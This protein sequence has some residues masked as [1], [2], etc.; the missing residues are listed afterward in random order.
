MRMAFG[1]VTGAAAMAALVAGL[2]AAPSAAAATV[3]GGR[4]VYVCGENLCAVDPSTGGQQQ[5]T[6]DAR[7]Y[8]TPDVTADG[9]L[10]A[11]DVDDD[12]FVGAYGTNLPEMWATGRSISDVAIAPDGSGV[13]E[14]HSY[15]QNVYCYP[16]GLCLRAFNETDYTP[17]GAPTR[18]GSYDGGNGAAFTGTGALL[19]GTYDIDRDL[20]AI[21]RVAT[22]AAED[23]ECTELVNG[24][25]PFT[26]FDVTA[27]G[28]WVVST[29]TPEAPEGQVAVSSVQLFSTS[30]GTATPAQ[31]TRVVATSAASPTFSPDGTWIAYAS[32][33]GWIYAAPTA[34]G[35]PVRLVQGT[36]PAW[37]GGTIPGPPVGPTPTDPTT[38]VTSGTTGIVKPKGVV[39]VKKN[40][41]PITVS[42][43]GAAAC[44]G[45]VTV[46]LKGKAL[47][48]PTAYDLQPGERAKVKAKLTRRGVK[49]LS[50]GRKVTVKIA[51]GGAKA[52]VTI[53]R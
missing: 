45:K 51:A 32:A 3:P 5:I 23:Q 11:A 16:G 1:R 38:P 8:R 52:K 27:D 9:A 46:V 39:R 30:V 33:D 4:V 36:S 49:L 6:T 26:A 21:C 47:T 42:C 19:S 10:V 13:A 15:V 24:P 53:R 40:K 37:G 31:P 22:P 25:D 44:S 35:D 50:K 2:S 18:R 14:S 20:H 43:S 29:V 17:R 28:A 34:G 12:V 41:L 48:K 7:G